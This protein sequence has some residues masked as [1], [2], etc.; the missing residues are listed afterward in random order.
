M[1]ALTKSQQ[2]AIAVITLIVICVIVGFAWKNGYFKRILDTFEDKSS[3]TVEYFYMEG[4][5][6]CDKF[7]P[8]WTKFEEATAKDGSITAKKTE[9][10]TAGD[11][12]KM[13]NIQGFPTVIVNKD[14]KWT[15]YSGE[16]NSDALMSF[17]KSV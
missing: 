14:G 16:R 9:A 10:S 12:I 13:Y 17:A 1:K 4:C 2:L 7:M 15:E 6:W 11:S 3:C 8:E 5:P